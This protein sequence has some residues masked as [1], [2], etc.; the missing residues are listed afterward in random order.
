[1]TGPKTI[2]LY[3]LLADVR[4]TVPIAVFAA[5]VSALFM[6]QSFVLNWLGESFVTT[7]R[8]EAAIADLERRAEGAVRVASD[9]STALEV[10]LKRQEVRDIQR[11][12]GTA[13]DQLDD[14]K[15]WESANG[16]NAQSRLRR[17]ELQNR[18]RTLE[19]RKDCILSGRG[20]CDI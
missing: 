11:D 5:I 8:Y 4:V 15:L 19:E 2:D 9:T 3:A 13:K 10:F 16:E 17:I 7:T 12:M 20:Y 14:L 18:I 1:M 6:G